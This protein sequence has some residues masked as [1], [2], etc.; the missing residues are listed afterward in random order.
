MAA[1]G[2]VDLVG[3]ESLEVFDDGGGGAGFLEGEL[4]VGV[5][6]FIYNIY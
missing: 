3:G 5:K 2:R 4:G 6:P 1:D